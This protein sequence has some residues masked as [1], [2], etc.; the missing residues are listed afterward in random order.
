MTEKKNYTI[1]FCGQ[2]V[3]INCYG[4]KACE[5]VEF[6]FVDLLVDTEIKTSY[7]YDIMAVGKQPMLS[8]WNG[9]KK[10]YFG[11]SSYS[12]AYIFVNGIIYQSIVKNDRGHVIHS[13]AV[14]YEGRG[15]LLPGNSGSGKST[16][17]AWLV[18]QGAN[19]LTDE[20]VLLS[21]DEQRIYPFTRP[22]SVRNISDTILESFF[23]GDR[24]KTLIGDDGYM[25]PHRLLNPNFSPDTPNLSLVIFPEYRPGAHVSLT[26]LSDGM[27]C[28]RLIS[29]YVNARNIEEHGISRLADIVRKTPVYHLVYSSFDDLPLVFGDIFPN[30]LK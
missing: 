12:L 24:D 5:I 7:T 14:G 30:L 20:L 13:A 27:A 17:T 2:Y 22:I 8:L 1:G 28:S 10:L 16:L 19:Y 3:T 9:E 26:K 25:L 23:K 15:V 21:T 4:R 29:C 18:A 11:E 6:L